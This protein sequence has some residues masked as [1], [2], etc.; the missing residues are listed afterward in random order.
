MNHFRSARRASLL[1]DRPKQD[2]MT[3]LY[4]AYS[5][6][7]QAQVLVLVLGQGTCTSSGPWYLCQFQA[8]VLVLGK[9]LSIV[10]ITQLRSRRVAESSVA[11]IDTSEEEIYVRRGRDA[12]KRLEYLLCKPESRFGVSHWQVADVHS[13]PARLRPGKQQPGG[14]HGQGLH[15]LISTLD[16]KSTFEAQMVSNFR[17]QMR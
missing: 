5:A 6:L 3:S 13:H 9:A 4:Q 11:T 1:S 7:V 12:K 16:S 17:W 14:K 10:T 8:Y 2:Q 15:L